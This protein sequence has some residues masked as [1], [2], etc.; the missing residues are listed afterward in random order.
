M[1]EVEVIVGQKTVFYLDKKQVQYLVNWKG[2]DSSENS[3][4]IADEL[5]KTAPE[6]VE[7]FKRAPKAKRMSGPLGP[8]GNIFYF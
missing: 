2:C 3:W 8:K 4:E 7:A 1:W 6:A 5:V